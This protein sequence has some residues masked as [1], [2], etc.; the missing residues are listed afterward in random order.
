MNHR[1]TLNTRLLP[2]SILIS[3]LVSGGAMA[4]TVPTGDFHRLAN[5]GSFLITNDALTTNSK[6]KPDSIL[7]SMFPAGEKIT[8]E[9]KAAIAN[10]LAEMQKSHQKTLVD[11]QKQIDSLGHVERKQA[12]VE[13]T[14]FKASADKKIQFLEAKVAYANDPTTDNLDALN[15]K[16]EDT[17]THTISSLPEA[18]QFTAKEIQS[19]VEAKLKN[20]DSI[21]STEITQKIENIT[22]QQQAELS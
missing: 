5:G 9:M 14:K 10:D 7:E 17:V 20:D 18:G 16:L 22:Q 1:N 3:S 21:L 13:L 15:K 12:E 2:L 19:L 6:N 11:I 4:A 8:E